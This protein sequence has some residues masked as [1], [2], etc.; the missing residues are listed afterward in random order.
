[1][2]CLWQ[3]WSLRKP[4]LFSCLG[5]RSPP[6]F[7]FIRGTCTLY[8][9]HLS[10]GDLCKLSFCTRTSCSLAPLY[11]SVEITGRVYVPGALE[12]MRRMRFLWHLEILKSQGE[13]LYST[14]FQ[15]GQVISRS[16]FKRFQFLPMGA[17]GEVKYSNDWSGPQY[18]EGTSRCAKRFAFL[19][20][21]RWTTFVGNVVFN[22][23]VSPATIITQKEV[24]QDLI[25]W[26]HHLGS[27]FL[28][29]ADRSPSLGRWVWRIKTTT[30]TNNRSI[31]VFRQ[32]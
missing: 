31:Y 20:N 25:G 17:Q 18:F 7:D 23:V 4:T 3:S 26:V 9:P 14:V 15:K 22:I 30:T 1:M 13:S 5:P 27:C 21:W 8:S 11:F 2:V 19:E 6:F 16:S 29:S 28:I 12:T 24:P 10:L 32:S